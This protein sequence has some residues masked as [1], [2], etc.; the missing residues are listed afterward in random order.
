MGR[1][2]L[3]IDTQ[4]DG[5]KT[6]DDAFANAHTVGV[7]ESTTQVLGTFQHVLMTNLKDLKGTPNWY[8][9]GSSDIEELYNR[10]DLSTTAIVTP[11][12]LAG[13]ASGTSNVLL[14][15]A[16][17]TGNAA[18][19]DDDA[20]INHILAYGSDSTGTQKTKTRVL[21]LNASTND[22]IEDGAGN[23]VYAEMELRTHP[24][25]N[26]TETNFPITAVDGTSNYQ[27]KLHFYSDVAGTPT[28]HTFGSSVSIDLYYRKQLSYGT[29]DKFYSVDGVSQYTDSANEVNIGNLTY[30]EQNEV[31]NGETVTASLDALDIKIGDSTFTESNDVAGAND[32]TENLDAIDVRIG[33]SAFTSQFDVTNNADISD[34][35]DALDLAHGN[36]TYTEDNEVTDN[37]TFTASIDALD[38]KIGDSTFTSAFNLTAAND[39]TEWLD[40]LDLAIGD[41]SGYTE[42]NYITNNESVAASLDALDQQVKDNTDAVADSNCDPYWLELGSTVT[43]GNPITLPASQTYTIDTNNRA[44]HMMVTVDGQVVAPDD[45]GG[46]VQD[47]DY[48]EASTTTIVAHF[49]IP[50]GSIIGFHI[51]KA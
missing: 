34:N 5:P 44:K 2:L 32:I 29:A 51:R 30:T 13:I 10:P 40:S 11:V 36:R 33:D 48:Q 16:N 15:G 1:S 47:Y 41:R 37:Q 4:V 23:E 24:D 25:T 19:V 9:T 18:L 31:T 17:L 50:A 20:S 26:L 42:Q 3:K 7:A 28:A 43:A 27:F 49:T 22:P 35:L 21:I 39:I 8:D 6:F 46:S 12:I 14:L 45:F 38:I